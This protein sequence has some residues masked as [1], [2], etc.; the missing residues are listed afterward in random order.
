MLNIDSTNGYFEKQF[1][2][3]ETT[4]QNGHIFNKQPVY[5]VTETK[6]AKSFHIEFK[7][8]VEYV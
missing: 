6:M 7:T 8:I 2:S 3:N 4:Y 5:S 1:I